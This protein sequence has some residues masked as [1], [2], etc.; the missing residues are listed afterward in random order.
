MN[1]MKT[2]EVP[3]STREEVNF[4]TC[5]LFGNKI[6]SETFTVDEVEISH[7]LPNNSLMSTVSKSHFSF[8]I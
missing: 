6:S 4:V 8:K 3:A 2:V 7:R 5:D 1:H